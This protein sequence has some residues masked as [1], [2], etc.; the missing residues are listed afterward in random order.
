LRD[1]HAKNP[2]PSPIR[3]WSTTAIVLIA[4]LLRVGLAAALASQPERYF[5]SDAPHYERL[6]NNLLE[7]HVFTLSE[8]PPLEP[9]ALRTPLYPLFMAAIYG[10]FGHRPFAIVLA[11]CAASMISLWLASHLAHRTFGRRAALIAALCMA[12]DLGQVIF[13]SLIMT[14]TVF[15]TLVVSSAWWTWRLVDATTS[16]RSE[17]GC[18]HPFRSAGVP[19]RRDRLVYA[20]L[21]GAS[22]GLAA[23]CRPVATYLPIVLAAVVGVHWLE[24]GRSRPDRFRKTCQVSP[25]GRSAQTIGRALGQIGVMGL[26]VLISLS[27]WLIRNALRFDSPQ[28]STIQGFN[29]LFH[30]T[31]YLR[32]RLDGSTWKE[33]FNQLRDDVEA[34]IG[35]QDLGQMELASYYQQ[36][37][38]RE[39]ASHPV[40]YAQA[41]ATGMFWFFATPNTNFLANQLGILRQPTGIIANLRTRNLSANLQA[42]REFWDEYVY[43]APV[44]L[45]FL[46]ALVSEILI[47]GCTYLGAL[48]GTVV[49]IRERQWASLALLLGLIGYF[50]FVTGPLGYARFRIPAMPFI[51]IL[52]GS[53][54]AHG[55]RKLFSGLLARR[56]GAA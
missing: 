36:K 6:A 30:N 4:V 37:A 24:Q 8:A 50:A 33:E 1:T 3:S 39:I 21:A 49:G 35:D 48:W 56:S 14:E 32:A 18:R 9:D 47:L 34:E 38:I 52:A 51:C 44:Q 28:L 5:Q 46:L 17:G 41:H 54:W 26:A 31:A 15:V 16:V 43:G 22:A 10:L 40:A 13:A 19:F 53:G 45:V 25:Q 55:L 11:Q 29:L 12:L 27:P 42:L 2:H 23:L 7:F 20:G